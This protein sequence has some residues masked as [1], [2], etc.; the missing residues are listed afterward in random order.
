E[1]YSHVID[2]AFD[3]TRPIRAHTC[4]RLHVDRIALPLQ[5]GFAGRPFT[6]QDVLRRSAVAL[7]A[8][9]G[10]G[11]QVAAGRIAQ[12]LITDV[13]GSSLYFPRHFR[14]CRFEVRLGSWLNL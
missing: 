5:E 14:E 2:A 4:S 7:Y 11:H 10:A 9:L 12:Q 13:A 3:S 1:T 6:E 8:R